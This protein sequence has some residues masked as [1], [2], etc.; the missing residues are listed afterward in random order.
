MS[1]APA[2]NHSSSTEPLQSTLAGDP[3]MAELV[4]YFVQEMDNR[5]QTIAS[6]AESND[7]DQ[8][9]VVAHQLK[10]AARGYGFEPIS[11]SAASLEELIQQADPAEDCSELG[12][13]IDE[14]IDLC[15][16]ASF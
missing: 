10:G 12:R 13:Q 11:Q 14:L 8:L 5:A 7:L 2:N 9:R 1:D 4:Q 16:R 15:R 6:A 3:D